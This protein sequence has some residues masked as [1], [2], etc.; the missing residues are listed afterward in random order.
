MSN[1]SIARG[2]GIS[3]NSVRSRIKTLARQSRLFEKQFRINT[4]YENIA[5]DGFETFTHSQFQ[6]CSLN[7]AVGSHS[8]FT[9]D[10][11]FSPLNR[12][13]RMTEEQVKK[14]KELLKTYGP[15]PQDSVYQESLEIIK[16]LSS[17][18]P[19]KTLYTDKHQAYDRAVKSFDCK[20]VHEK[21]D[22]K[23]RR[24]PTNPLFPINR[25]HNN[26][27]HYLS[28]Q[29][30]ETISF[31]KHEAALLEK[32]QLMKTYHNFMRTKFVKKNKFD[33]LA[34]ENSP[35][36]YLKLTKKVLNFDEV[37][38]V[39]KLKSQFKLN[40]YDEKFLSRIYPYSRQ[41]IA[42]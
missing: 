25:L 5:Y 17:L 2:I 7:T 40:D 12:K 20:L 39:R 26:Y 15:Y 1:N 10:V 16:N 11:T 27:R 23:E 31:H 6:P 41:N 28:S 19:G 21:I 9:Y 33:P 24:D 35:A 37:F 36:M 8:M 22:S 4:I 13:G 3:E 18:A 14:Q 34:H 32:V 29:H 42:A 30:R 38:G